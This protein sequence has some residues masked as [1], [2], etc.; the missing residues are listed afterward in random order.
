ME[1]VMDGIP[2]NIKY[3]NEISNGEQGFL[4]QVFYDPSKKRKTVSPSFYSLAKSS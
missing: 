1:A 3:H 2:K 4:W